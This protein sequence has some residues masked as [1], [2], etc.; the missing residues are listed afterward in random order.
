MKRGSGTL[1]LIALSLGANLRALAQRR[2]GKIEAL[3]HGGF[4]CA[5]VRLVEG[6]NLN[7][8]ATSSKISLWQIY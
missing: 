8:R 7:D 1:I 5:A 2:F 6:M 3:A 4:H